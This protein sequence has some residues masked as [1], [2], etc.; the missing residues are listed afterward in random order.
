MKISVT[1][2]HVLLAIAHFQWQRR[3]QEVFI[4]YI[5]TADGSSIHSYEPDMKCQSAEWHCPILLQKKV[6]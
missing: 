4:S 1:Y 5:L 3:E 2:V 6:A